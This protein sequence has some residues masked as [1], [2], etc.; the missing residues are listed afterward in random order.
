MLA[1][2]RNLFLNA[3]GIGHFVYIKQ[4][5]NGKDNKNGDHQRF[6]PFCSVMLI[7]ISKIFI[8]R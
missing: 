3:K 6:P 1:F 7:T 5:K 4:D 8:K 2:F